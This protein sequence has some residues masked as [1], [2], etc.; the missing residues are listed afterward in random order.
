MSRYG[1]SQAKD[2]KAQVIDALLKEIDPEVLLAGVL[3]GTATLGG[4][5]PPMTRF[6]SVM[7]GGDLGKD[8]EA[9]W[10]VLSPATW[11]NV[12]V[13]EMLFG[14]PGDGTQGDPKTW[15]LAASGALEAMIMMT[16]VKNPDLLKTVIGTGK[17]LA[18][19]TIRAGG[20]AVPF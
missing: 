2:S 20:E 15:A 11:S 12:K 7:G 16:L 14:S 18:A 6:L 13:F 8:Y 10:A 19:A 1:K 5:T 17:D 3:G 4:I 9:L